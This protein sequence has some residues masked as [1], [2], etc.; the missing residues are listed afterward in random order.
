MGL[1][2]LGRCFRST[3]GLH[4]DIAS[5]VPEVPTGPKMVLGDASHPKGDTDVPSIFCLVPTAFCRV[6]LPED[7]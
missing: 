2:Q 1:T 6:Y 7:W 5:A 3:A 4:G